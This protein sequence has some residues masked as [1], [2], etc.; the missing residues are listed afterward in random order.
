MALNSHCLPTIIFHCSLSLIGTD[1]VIVKQGK[2]ICGSGG[3]LCC[4]PI[5][6]DK[7]YFEVKVQSSGKRGLLFALCT[8]S[9]YSAF[10]SRVFAT[11]CHQIKKILD[12]SD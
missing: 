7:A 1:V 10:S 11:I 12:A 9:R 3:A 5:V 2:R 6:Q 4:V 8:I